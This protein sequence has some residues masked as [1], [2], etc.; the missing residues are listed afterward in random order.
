MQAAV[1]RFLRFLSV[2]RN[3]ASLT[4]KSYR[5]DLTALVDYLQQAY[6]RLPAPGEITPLDL[7][8]YVSAMHEA[9][10]AKT[11]VSR[12]LA[13]LRTFYKFA[14]R[15][16]LADSNPAKPLRNPRKDLKLPHFLSTEEIG[17]LLTAPP[18]TSNQGLRDRAILETMYSAGLRVS[19][20]VGMNDGDLDLDEGLVR[21]RGKGRRERFSP[22]GSF[23]LKALTRWLAKRTLSP[24]EPTNELAPIFTNRFGRRLTTRSVARMLE[25]YLKTSGLDLRTTPHTLRH[26]FATHLLDRGADIRSV[27]EL[28]GHKSLVTTQIYTHIS[29]AG[30]RAVY[31][32]AHPRAKRV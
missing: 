26:S 11:S 8:G 10:Y 3:A 18:A 13:S 6:G 28:L 27:Q 20:V 31:E 1:T 24:K 25:K 21:I 22:L 32:R 23:A 7:R 30:L 2:E 16:G 5:E 17:L 29:T 9:G 15:E 19:E 12:R 14:Q 4:I